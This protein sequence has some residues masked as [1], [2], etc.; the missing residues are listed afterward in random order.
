MQQ[1]SDAAAAQANGVDVAAVGMDA[2]HLSAEGGWPQ[3]V[4]ALA[5]FKVVK[6]RV[7]LGQVEAELQMLQAEPSQ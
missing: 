1:A 4:E 3:G 5:G 6:F 2:M 7:W